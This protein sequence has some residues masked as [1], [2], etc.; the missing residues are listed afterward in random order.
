MTAE[1]HS[2][3]SIKVLVSSVAR[4]HSRWLCSEI[5]TGSGGWVSEGTTKRFGPEPT[6]KQH[7]HLKS[8]SSIMRTNTLTCPTNTSQNVRR[9]CQIWEYSPSFC[10]VE[11]YWLCSLPSIIYAKILLCNSAKPWGGPTDTTRCV[12]AVRKEEEEA[13][14]WRATVLH[15]G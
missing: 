6:W 10:C 14:K 2:A 4:C 7:R 11:K 15:W 5:N 1:W 12:T 9:G 3:S 13:T 8:S